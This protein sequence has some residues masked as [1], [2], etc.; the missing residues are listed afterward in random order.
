[1]ILDYRNYRIN[2]IKEKLSNS[3]QKSA[4]NVLVVELQGQ[5]SLLP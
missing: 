5:E 3:S 2:E 1:M 4:I